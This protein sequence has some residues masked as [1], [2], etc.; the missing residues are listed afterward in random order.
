MSNIWEKVV[1]VLND[2]QIKDF[3]SGKTSPVIKTENVVTVDAKTIQQAGIY[4]VGGLVLSALVTATII[5]IAI[6]S[7]FKSINVR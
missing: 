7:A 5:A 1:N 6:R 3:F 4:I 2:Q